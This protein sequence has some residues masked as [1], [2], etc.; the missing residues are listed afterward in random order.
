MYIITTVRMIIQF[1]PEIFKNLLCARHCF[2][3]LVKI[4][5]GK[6]QEENLYPHETYILLRRQIIG[7]E[8][9]MKF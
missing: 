3:V 6:K 9:G 2:W 5:M 1:I 4:P 8:L 7:S